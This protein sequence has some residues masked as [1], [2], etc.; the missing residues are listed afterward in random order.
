M[1]VEH[2]ETISPTHRIQ[3]GLSSW[4]NGAEQSV[5][6]AYYR[7]NNQ[8]NYAGSAEVGI[9][10]LVAMV[11]LAIESGSLDQDNIDEIER[12]IEDSKITA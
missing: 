2:E 6:S 9:P 4:G 11:R 12:A 5:R 7:D 8:F 1:Q 3:V 10:D